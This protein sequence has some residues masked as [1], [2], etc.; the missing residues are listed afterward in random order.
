VEAVYW[1]EVL[2]RGLARQNQPAPGG[3]HARMKVLADRMRHFV[4]GMNFR[5]LYDTQRRVF[6]IG[7]RLADAEGPGRLDPSYYDLL[8]SEARLASFIAIAKG[9]VPQAHW[10]QLGRSVTSVDG[11]PTL[12]SW[13]ATMFEY[14]MPLLVLRSYPGTLL[15]QTCRMAVR[16]QIRF[17]E[18]HGIP[19]GI[20][21]SAYDFV[22]RHNNY[23]YKAFG[24]P[25]LGLKRGLGDELVVSPYSTAL[26]ALVDPREALKNLR[27]LA[28]EGLDGPFGL[29][30]AIDYTTRQRVESD[31]GDRRALPRGAV[32]QAYLAHHQ[33]MTL[34]ALANV[35]HR[36]AMVARF[37]LDP[38]VQATELLLQERMPRRTPITEPRP[39]ES[40][41]VAPAPLALS[42]RRFRSPHTLFP[43]AQFLSNGAYTAV[44]T[45]AGGGWSTCRGLAVTRVSDDRTR[46]PGSQFVYLRDVRTG[47]TWSAAFQPTGREPEDYLVTYLDDKAV[48][49]RRDEEVETQLEITVSPEDDVEVRRLSLTN[50]SD[51][52]R[53]I[54]VTSYAEVVLAPP[55]DDLAHPAFAK[56]FIETEYIGEITALVCRRRPRRSDET[57]TWGIHVVSVEGRIQGGVEW[58]TDRARFLGRGRGADD[59]VALDGRPLSGTTGC[60]LDPIVSLR[61]RVR[62]APGGFVRLS[63]ATGLAR[64]RESALTLA[65]KY[66]DPSAPARTFA[67]AFTHALI[68]LRHLAITSD[69]AQ[70]FDRLASRLVFLDASL[71]AEPELLARNTLGQPGLWGHGISGDLPIL[72]VRV[73]EEDDLPLVRQV[74]QAQ[75]YWRLKGLSADVV[76][77]NEHPVGYLDEMQQALVSLL[78]SGP[79]S[80]WKHV[81]GGVFLLRGDVIPAPEKVLLAAAARAVLSG[82]R[83]DLAHQLDI[84]YSEPRWPPVLRPVR[85]EDRVLQPEDEPP[86]VP[87]LTLANGYGGFAREGREYVIVLERA[88]ETPLPWAN[89]LANPDFG[90][91]ITASGAACTWAEN[92]RQNR[93]TPFANDPVTDPTGEAIFIRDDQGGE[94]WSATPAP[95]RDA[96]AGRWVVRH[97]AGVSRFAH[98]RHGIAHETAVF[99]A[100][101]APVK[102]SLLKLE[103]RTRRRRRLSLFAYNEWVL[104]PPRAGEH[105]HVVTEADPETEA[106]L[107]RNPFNQ[108]F[109]GRVAFASATEPL[110]SATGDRLEFVGR[111]SSLTQP[112]ALRREALAG[113][114]GAGLDP[115]AALHVVLELGPGETRTI[116]F[117]LGQGRDRAQALGLARRYATAAAAEAELAQVE[118]AWEQVLGAVQVKTPDDSFDVMMNRWLLYQ[119]FACRVWARSGYYQP[120]GAFGFRDQLQDVMALALSRPELYR[121]HILRAASRQFVEGDVQHWWHEPSGRGTRTRCS[122]DLLWLPFVAAAYVETTADH[123]VLDEVVPFLEAPLLG[124]EEHESYLQPTVSAAAATLYE[125]CLRAIDRGLT[126]GPQ[127]LP[128]IGTGDWNDGMNRVGHRGR[129]E[130]VWLGWFLYSVLTRFAPLCEAREDAARAARYRREADRLTV[131]LERAWDG[132]WYRRGYFDDGTPLGSAQSEECRIDSIA[133]SWAVLSA[134]APGRRA[135]RAMDAVRAHLVRRAAKVILLLTPPFDRSA[136]DP[137]YIKGYPPGVRENGGQYTHA[138]LWTVMALAQLGSG[139]EAMEL[140]HMVN[141]VNHARSSAEVDVYK[142][143]P[144]VVAGDVYA[145]PAHTGRSGWTWY[146]GS[147]GWMYR[148]GLETMLG[149][150]RRGATFEVSPCIPAAWAGYTITWRFGGARYEIAVENPERRNRGVA[151]VELDGEEVDP[152]LIPLVDDG[153]VHRVRVI[154]GSAAVRP[155]PAVAP[156]V[157]RHEG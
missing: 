61:Q 41:R 136:L 60:V 132:E 66:H 140:F 24:I 53:E 121:A 154:V 155:A 151:Y 97:A 108:E 137:G 73:V 142:A 113:R 93:M 15:D 22:D 150:K 25:G 118:R 69:D 11:I 64:S 55:A 98:A 6:A 10:F 74:L 19:W 18:A 101:S 5:F 143:E 68:E 8:A 126:A 127:G 104:G 134:A 70:L 84:P 63:F 67:L 32:V 111:N 27:R 116:A 39:P 58:E 51:R 152:A 87:P 145:H 157:A 128:L 43:H 56:L 72:L 26:A 130:S 17:G 88:Q 57:E 37:H 83:G 115:C 80:A 117:A 123:G 95:L 16:K 94:V 77:L 48:F 129:G 146:T 148:V 86:P 71:R 144:Y 147:A 153:A 4:D 110:R 124:P 90:S 14:L 114:F 106:V 112:R 100:E 122:D 119:A 30:E 133:Q 105:L 103:N 33:G 36:N 99:V 46:D 23:Q 2:R 45:N 109:P 138:A 102:L 54:E 91:V 20:S 125:H 21:E 65:Q 49:R 13:S 1:A 31:G 156:A 29:Y 59:P 47:A 107:A 44:V 149:L 62:L 139:D 50:R 135:E 75:E 12:L 82:E 85:G 35:L 9:D 79:W 52:E 28:A 40:P 42:A 96:E 78:E 38:R 34:V 7:Y 81:S 89:V 3:L 92:S 141:P 131:S 120:G 76:I